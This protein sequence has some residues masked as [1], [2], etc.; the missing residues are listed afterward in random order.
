MLNRLTTPENR[1]VSPYTGWTKEHWRE[2]QSHILRATA[3]YASP[4]KAYIKFPGEQSRVQGRLSDWV[5]G[6]ARTSLYVGPT[7]YSGDPGVIDLSGESFDIAAFY[8]EGLL[9]GTNPRGPEYWGDMQ[10]LNQ[11]L[12]EAAAIAM[13]LWLSKERIWDTLSRGE[14]DQVIAWLGQINL[15]KVHQCNWTQFNMIVNT[16]LKHLGEPHSEEQMKTNMDI[17]DS[18]Y[19]SD[20]WYDD[21]FRQAFDNYNAYVLHP[22]FLFWSWLDGD[23]NPSFRDRVQEHAHCFLKTYNHF[24]G[25]N[26]AYPAFGRSL[27]YRYSVIGVFSLAELLNISPLSPGEA[28][29]L[30]SGNLKYFIEAGTLNDDGAHSVRY[31]TPCPQAID[32]YSGPGS[33]YWSGKAFW[34]FLLPDDHAFWTDP[35]QPLPVEKASYSFN[36]P[37]PGILVQGTKETGEIKLYHLLTSM[38]PG[39]E[40][41]YG[42]FCYSNQFGCDPGEY[43]LPHHIEQHIALVEDGGQPTLRH[44][45]DYLCSTPS[46]G[47]TRHLPYLDDAQTVIES[48]I[49]LKDDFHIRFHKVKTTRTVTIQ[50]GGAALG[51]EDGAPQVQSGDGW[52]FCEHEGH[53]SFVQSLAGYD[54]RLPAGGPDGVRHECNVLHPFSVVPGMTRKGEF[55]GSVI[56]GLLIAASGK[57]AGPAD[58][59]KLVRE[60]SIAGNTVTVCFHDGERVFTQFMDQLQD[61]DIELNGKPI[62][63]RVV[64][65]RVQPSGKGSIL[66]ENG[67]LRELSQERT[68]VVPN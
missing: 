22:Y 46:F 25:S 47:A 61:V 8:L 35:E 15:Y 39:M 9:S 3:Q 17:A 33:P 59:C 48:H 14:K 28:R 67:E 27:V 1:N 10:D 66:D 4:E 2:V 24:F 57:P 63:G 23:A 20:G 53:W 65:A 31:T 45:P 56:T 54:G 43:F 30:A 44:H 40:K 26:G 12:C 29:R 68:H 13:F 21:G 11:R 16:V 58:L 41:K 36:L 60:V 62:Q 52:E 19:V 55:D 18:F 51:Y 7:L 49:I 32:T 64:F 6:Y 5:E 37:G 50:E 42:N 38:H 34:S